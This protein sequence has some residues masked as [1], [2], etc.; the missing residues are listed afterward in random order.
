M[1][2]YNSI[3]IIIITV[4]GTLAI[5]GSAGLRTLSRSRFVDLI[6]TNYMACVI[7]RE[8]NTNNTIKGYSGCKLKDV[9]R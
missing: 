2:Y 9:S 4:G 3:T 5:I 1:R 7:L 8:Y 6:H